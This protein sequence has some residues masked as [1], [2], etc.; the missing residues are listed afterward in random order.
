MKLRNVVLALAVVSLVAIP[1]FA[2]NNKGDVP[3]IQDLAVQIIAAEGETPEMVEF[4]WADITEAEKYSL[5]IEGAGWVTI[6]DVVDP[7]WVEFSVS[8]S[9]VASPLALPVEDVLN[10]LAAAVLAE[11][12]VEIED[13]LGGELLELSAKVKGLDPLDK[14]D[15]KSQDNMFSE[16]LD[17]MPLFD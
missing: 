13:V 4:S 1:A 2:K 8:Y 3:Q 9:A 11:L 6:V 12:G 14:L 5:D 16:S 10:D 7:V 15:V 17:L